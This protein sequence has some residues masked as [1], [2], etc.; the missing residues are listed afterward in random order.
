MA[1]RA[2]AIGLV[3]AGV[4]CTTV[5]RVQPTQ[6][7]PQHRPPFVLVT[8]KDSDVTNVV[9]PQI[10]GD[11]LRG[12]VAGLGERV[13]IPLSDIVN[14]KANAP[15]GTKTAILL[16]A[17]AIAS[18]ATVYFL[19]QRSTPSQPAPCNNPDPDLCP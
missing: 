6:F 2:L 1:S 17:S 14:V 18:G 9:R 8:T 7:I 15:D 11:T 4:A 16:T 13:A 19:I 5:Q 3:L 10:D 12:T